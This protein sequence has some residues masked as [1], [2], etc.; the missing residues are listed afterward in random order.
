VVEATTR[1]LTVRARLPN[2]QR[3]LR[4]G[5][6]ADVAVIVKEVPSALTV[7]NVAVIPE[8]GGKK[9]MV[10]E[11]GVVASRQVT[12][13]IRTDTEIEITSGLAPGDRVIVRGLESAKPGSEVDAREASSISGA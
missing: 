10:V 6:F 7:P 8:L 5:A 11:D 1:S 12:T 4:P 2:P 9:V 3:K 13:G